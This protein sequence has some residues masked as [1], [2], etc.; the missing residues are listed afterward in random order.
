MAIRY[1]VYCKR[2]VAD[3][4]P[5]QLLAAKFDGIIRAAVL[6]WWEL[7]KYHEYQRMT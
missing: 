4:T 6:T 2:S 5:A 3:V 7:G 1:T